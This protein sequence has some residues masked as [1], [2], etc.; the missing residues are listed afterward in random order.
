MGGAALQQ[1]GL[2]DEELYSKAVILFRGGNGNVCSHRLKRG[3]LHQPERS[4]IEPVK[5]DGT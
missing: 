5:T 1:R 4:G 2:Y 3:K